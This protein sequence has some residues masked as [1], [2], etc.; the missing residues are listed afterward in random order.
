MTCTLILKNQNYKR[1]YRRAEYELGSK[2]NTPPHPPVFYFY[3]VRKLRTLGILQN[4]ISNP[5]HM[6]SK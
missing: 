5:E 3:F 4:L 6:E 1:P 2:P